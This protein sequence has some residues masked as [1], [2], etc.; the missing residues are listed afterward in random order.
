MLY[1]EIMFWLH[2][3]RCAKGDNSTV[4]RVRVKD[5]QSCQSERLRWCRYYNLPALAHLGLVRLLLFLRNC[6]CCTADSRLGL[7]GFF[8]HDFLDH[9]AGSGAALWCWVDG[10][11][12]FCCTCIFFSM[13]VHPERK[14]DR[15][16]RQAE[17]KNKKE[18]LTQGTNNP[19]SLSSFKYGI[20]INQVK[21]GHDV[22]MTFSS[23][24][25]LCL[26]GD[27]LDS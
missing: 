21:N 13:N 26:F 3:C 25:R 1:L 18:A 8:L 15:E 24:L 10:D 11:G 5:V 22:R 16:G 7:T 23:L 14:R 2:T 4:C 17:M 20:N 19:V 6:A 27:V 9:A 12:L